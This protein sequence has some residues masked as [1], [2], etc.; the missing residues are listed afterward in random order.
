MSGFIAADGSSIAGALN[1]GNV[2]QALQVDALLNQ[3]VK[4]RI[5]V[6]PVLLSDAPQEPELPP[7][8]GTL[9]WVDFHK[10]HPDPMTRLVWGITGVRPKM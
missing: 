9:V 7:F 2:G 6:I 1:P 3:F 10:N 4:R 8:L 5:P